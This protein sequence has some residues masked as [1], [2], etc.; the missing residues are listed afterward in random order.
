LSALSRIFLH[1][2]KRSFLKKFKDSFSFYPTDIEIYLQ[3]FRHKSVSIYPEYNNERLEFLGDTVLATVFSDFLYKRYPL[4]NEGFLTQIRAK[5]T[6]RTFLNNLALEM[7]F[8][9]FVIYD[10]S[11]QLE[12]RPPN[13]LFGNA[14]EAFVGALYLDKGYKYTYA[15]VVKKVVAKHI[16]INTVQQEEDNYKGRLYELVQKDKKEIK[17]IMEETEEEH[18]KVYTASVIIDGTEMGKGTGLKKKT[19]EQQA[20]AQAYKKLLN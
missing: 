20:A 14:L 12:N 1:K 4:E 18:H 9:H 17:F 16:D 11:I 5:L 6:N 7:G 8:N 3:A 10:S 2:S 13:N 15:Y 19:A